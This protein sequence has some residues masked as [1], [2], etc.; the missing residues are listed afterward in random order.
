MFSALASY[1]RMMPG[2]NGIHIFGKSG[3]ARRTWQGGLKKPADELRLTVGFGFRE[4]AVRVGAHRRLG[5]V[6]PR[7]GDQP[8]AANDFRE[9]AGLGNGQP[10]IFRQSA[11]FGAPR[12]AAGSTAKTAAGGSVLP[13]WF[14]SDALIPAGYKAISKDEG[15]RTHRR[16]PGIMV[17]AVSACSYLAPQL[18]GLRSS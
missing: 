14:K 7:G 11:Q 10:R 18:R 15:V 1:E 9:N 5:D 16:C 13:K 4:N 6:E 17:E 2:S 8:V 12:P 3:A